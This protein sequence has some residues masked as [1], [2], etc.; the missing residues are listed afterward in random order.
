M[1]WQITSHTNTRTHWIAARLSEV[2]PRLATAVTK[3]AQF[4]QHLK[5]SQAVLD[6]VT[7]FPACFP[8]AR[9]VCTLSETFSVKRHAIK[10]FSVNNLNIFLC[11]DALPYTFTINVRMRLKSL[12]LTTAQSDSRCLPKNWQRH[13]QEPTWTRKIQ[14]Q[15]VNWWNSIVV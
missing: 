10:K 1:S 12:C 13:G 14:S 5:N 11:C 9:H 6:R 7:T 4:W 15:T 3:E 2:S 8:E